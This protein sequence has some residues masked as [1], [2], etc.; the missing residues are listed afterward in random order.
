MHKGRQQAKQLHINNKR[1]RKGRR[2]TMSRS[3]PQAEQDM[4]P[5][6]M[7][8]HPHQ[9]RCTAILQSNCRSK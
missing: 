4:A 9:Q 7:D 6:T 3:R 5:E 1:L 8:A 2:L